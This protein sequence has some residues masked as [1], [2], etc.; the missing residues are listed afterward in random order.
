MVGQERMIPALATA[1]RAALGGVLA[2]H[3]LPGLGKTTLAEALCA[4]MQRSFPGRVCLIKFP[5]L[6]SAQ[7][8]TEREDLLERGLEQLGGQRGCPTWLEEVDT[9]AIHSSDI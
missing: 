4:S 1:L 5:T 3:G 6:D 7:P 2:L 9:H 8:M